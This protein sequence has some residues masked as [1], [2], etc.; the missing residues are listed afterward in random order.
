MK[1]ASIKHTNIYQILLRYQLPERLVTKS[2]LL[3]RM[4]NTGMIEVQEQ[5]KYTSLKQIIPGMLTLQLSIS[6]GL[7]I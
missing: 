3:K 4:Q 5:Q 1:R 7:I 6:D 2:K